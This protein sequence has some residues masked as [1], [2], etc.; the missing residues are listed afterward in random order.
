MKYY[1]YYNTGG[2]NYGDHYCK[3]EEFDDLAAV[4]DRIEELRKYELSDDEYSVIHGVDMT[5]QFQ[6]M[7]IPTTEVPHN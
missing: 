4:A 7:A 3:L 6:Q 1:L 2:C 5:K